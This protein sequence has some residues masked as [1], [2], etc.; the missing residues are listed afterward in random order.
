MFGG[1]GAPLLEDHE[2]ASR[3][4]DLRAAVLHNVHVRE[5][6]HQLDLLVDVVEYVLRLA[7]L[8][9]QARSF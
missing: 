4:V 3:P 9:A 2:L 7:V 1:G 8:P 5:R 6:R